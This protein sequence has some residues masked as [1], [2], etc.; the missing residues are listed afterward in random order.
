[1]K[2]IAVTEVVDALA[3]AEPRAKAQAAIALASRAQAL[4]AAT[5]PV[6]I[7]SCT[8]VPSEPGR[9]AKPELVNPSALARRGLGSPAGRIA[10]LHSLA[11]IEFNAIDLALD[12]VARFR[13]QPSDY[14]A[15][16][17][18]V[19]GDEGQHFVLVAD[20]L[21]ALGSFYGALPAHDGLWAMARR[22]E[23][24]V[25][26]RMALVPRILEARGL[27]VAPP[28]IERLHNAGD[29]ESAAILQRIYTDEITHV[30]VGNRWFR[31]V[32]EQRDLDGAE[33]FRDLLRGGHSV[34]LRGPYN[35]A[36]RLEA[37]FDP[38]E[39]TLIREME[40]EYSAA[41]KAQLAQEVA[42]KAAQE[43]PA[44]PATDG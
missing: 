30:A 34:W 12:A 41:Q 37:G 39:L 43:T 35:D 2:P 44:A 32:C 6:V 1:M 27:D 3:L 38:A 9:P 29:H 24:D 17:L 7:G 8:A 28:M 15:Q 21:E 16:W 31:Y 13:G 10:L 40:A 18:R 22:T 11:H 20:R 42:Q 36:A 33:V 23:H 4:S 14:D 19:A 5:Q 25:L 26:V